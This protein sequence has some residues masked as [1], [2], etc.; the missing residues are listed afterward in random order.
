MQRILKVPVDGIVGKKTIEAINNY[1]NQRM[2]FG[3]IL[4]E[5][6]SFVNKIVKNNPSQKKFL[7]GWKNRIVAFKYYDDGKCYKQTYINDKSRIK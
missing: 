7:N 2:L 1:P 4:T 3:K 6:L 5:R